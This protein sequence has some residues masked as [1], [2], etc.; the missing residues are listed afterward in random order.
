MAATGDPLSPDEH[1]RVRAVLYL[2]GMRTDA[3]ED[4]VQQVRVKLLEQLRTRGRPRHRG[5]WLATVAGRVALDTHRARRH[6][7]GLAE[8]IRHRDPP[9]VSDRGRT[10]EER[11]L[12]LV[13]EQALQSLDQDVRRLVVL[14]FYADLSVRQIA[15]QLGVPEGTVKSRLHAAMRSLRER[16]RE[17]EVV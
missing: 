15:E 11:E 6:E 7:R 13:V 5:A 10:A 2:G 17:T 16:L 14:R 12:A 3:L 1:D 4:G 9:Q 8:R